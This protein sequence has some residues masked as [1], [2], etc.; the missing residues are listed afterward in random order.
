MNHEGK[1]HQNLK[2]VNKISA[3]SITNKVKDMKIKKT[4]TLKNN[5]N[6]TSDDF[7]ANDVKRN[8]LNESDDE[9]CA[10]IEKN[11]ENGVKNPYECSF[12][13]CGQKFARKCALINH[14]NYRHQSDC[15]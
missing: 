4:E 7:G 1:Q 9:K 14:C 5:S 12:E 15:Y 2:K 8:F 10:Q 6:K 13:N 11:C 3:K